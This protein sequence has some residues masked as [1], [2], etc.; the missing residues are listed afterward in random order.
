M[1]HPGIGLTLAALAL[2]GIGAQIA[3]AQESIIDRFPGQVA[4]GYAPQA[5]L[6]SDA[7]GNLYG[8]AY[9]GGA[10]YAG[11]VFE[12][13][14]AQG[15]GWTETLLYSFDT[16][17]DGQN[18]LGSLVFDKA[19]NLYGTLSDGGANGGGSV[20]ELSPGA[21]GVWTE[22][23]LYPFGAVD[24]VGAY[25]Q[26]NLILDSEGNLYGTTES[27]T[28]TGGFGTVFELSPGAG[29][30]WTEKV[31]HTFTQYQ[32][33]GSPDGAQP[34]G[35]LIFD[36][37]GNL[38]GTTSADGS[39]NGGGA[40]G[41]V[42]ELSPGAGGVWTEKQLWG[43]GGEPDGAGPAANLIFDSQ[44]NLYG[45]THQGGSNGANEGTVFELS[46]G[47]GG[48]W[49][50]QLL[51]SFAGGASDG[52]QPYDTLIFDAQGDLYGT[53]IF[54]GPNGYSTLGGYL[55]GTAFELS[56]ASGGTWTEAILH[57]FYASSTDGYQSSAGLV[58]D[59]L[60][61]LYGTTYKGGSIDNNGSVFELAAAA[62]P[63][64][65]PAA[66]ANS[67]T[68]QVTIASATTDAAIYYTING[69]TPTPSSSKYTSPI[70]VA[71]GD[72]IEAYATAT[73]YPNSAVAYATVQGITFSPIAGQVAATTIDLDATATSGLA[74]SFSSLT[75]L[76]CTVSGATT[77]LI[78]AGSCTIQATQAGNSTYLAA[79]PVDQTFSVEHAS[80][81]IGFTPVAAGQV[82]ATH[83]NLS[84][85]AT[86]GLAVTFSSLTPSI[87]TVS[88]TTASLISFGSCTIEA[89]QAGN[90]E[91]FAA[92][93][94]DQTFGVGHASQ[95]ISFTPIAAGHVAAT[96]VNLAATATS[97]LTVS[98]SSLTPS[99]CTV[100]GT[101]AS[102]ISYGSCTVQASQAGNNEYFGAP[103]VNQTFGVA[104]ASQ[105]IGF[106]A[107]TGSHVAA[108]TVNLS[109][110]A[111]SGLTVSFSS[112]TPSVCTVAG[113]TASLI[114]Y[115]F[116]SIQ[117][118]QAGNN[119]Y[120]AA[121]AVFQSFGVGHAS[122][123]ITFPAISGSHVAATTLNLAATA[124][125]GL[126][127]SFASATPTVCTV[128]GATASLI[129]EGF[130]YISASQAGN[131][132]YFAAPT[133]GQQFGVGHATQTITYTPSGPL[134]AASTVNL[135]PTAS[136]GLPVTLVSTSPSVCTISGTTATLHTY[137]FCNVTASVAGNGEY[138]SA[139]S[140]S[141]FGIGHAS[142]TI[143]FPAIPTQYVGLPLTLSATA[144]SGLA[145]T[146]ASTTTS[147]CAVSG[148]TAS[149]IAT[150]TCHI[151]A[152][153]P[154]NSTYSG[155]AS[156]SRS[157]TVD[158]N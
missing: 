17:T 61:N 85:S 25:P 19:G 121:P 10:H 43:F 126:P 135:N 21:G 132:E 32:I 129:A 83:V 101:T 46:P 66:G 20:F 142:Q 149:F 38:Y 80:Q 1:K 33:V 150:G 144:S 157:F 41:T 118:T 55:A 99:V 87:C 128:A 98:F 64:F 36:A 81:T 127:V 65:A 75:P 24:T 92:P 145:V 100:S 62:L 96:N 94:V 76:V 45:T 2:L 116:C 79:T 110:T 5:S 54:G 72:T 9:S 123:T 11:A 40:F 67:E 136:S 13:S 151:L 137:G 58:A 70:E 147:V 52:A 16:Y 23:I 8:T 115:G 105:T 133:V 49:T 47:T 140:L 77:S 12:L 50:E 119:E 69:T 117:A 152:S 106:P 37:Q 148:T 63:A 74:V 153:Q 108:T 48:V 143:S 113:T 102:L 111:T 71:V 4:D 73:G 53:A 124:S 120:F 138:F 104:H 88:G 155:A 131:G 6:I 109:A 95:T 29:G 59:S 146:F 82:A 34:L 42:F 93:A 30:V 15:G 14:P 22:Q 89:D 57:N 158:P 125:S 7:Q 97:G 107:I 56:P 103:S 90:G 44:G 26:A 51:W 28:S 156:V 112:T 141:S 31:L 91:Y 39:S 122:Q 84:A 130:C 78:L 35:G 114:S 27:T 86:S 154:G 18:P 60:G 134:V 68:Q 3:A 139:T